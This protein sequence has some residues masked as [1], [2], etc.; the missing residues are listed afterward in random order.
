[1][2]DRE[3]SCAKVK[4]SS[5]LEADLRKGSVGR[6]E[7]GLAICNQRIQPREGNL[8]QNS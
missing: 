5:Y 3:K 1:M 8:G 4:R 7:E 2:R 6:L